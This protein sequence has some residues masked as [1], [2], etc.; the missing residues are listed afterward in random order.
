MSNLKLRKEQFRKSKPRSY[1][2]N[3][4]N[5]SFLDTYDYVPTHPRNMRAI[6]HS[7]EW[8]DEEAELRI[9]GSIPRDY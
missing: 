6:D 9:S 8:W 4:F 2:I 1:E 7:K 5:F 3:A